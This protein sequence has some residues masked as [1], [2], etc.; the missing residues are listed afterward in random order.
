M[1]APVKRGAY[2]SLLAMAHGEKIEVL[3][4]D[5]AGLQAVP[6]QCRIV[7]ETPNAHASLALIAVTPMSVL[8]VPLVDVDQAVPL[9]WTIAPLLPTAHTSEADVPEMSLRSS[10]VGFV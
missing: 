8:V 9:K 10:V 2:T 7:P 3:V 6:F 5:V 1:T 4:G